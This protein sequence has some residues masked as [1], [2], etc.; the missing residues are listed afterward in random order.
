[1]SSNTEVPKELREKLARYIIDVKEKRNLGFNQLA[2]KA[3]INVKSLNLLLNG[4][5]KRIN[6]YQLQ[7]IA[8]ALK[9]DYKKLYEIVGY[10][11]SEEEIL[12]DFSLS[13]ITIKE[14]MVNVPVYDSL[15]DGVG[16]E[17]NSDPIDF[18]TLP[19]NMVENCV[20]IN[21]YD[22]SMRPTLQDGCRILVK[23]NVEINEDD[24]GVF[25][26]NGEMIVKRY[27]KFKNRIYLC[28]DNLNYPSREVRKEDSFCICGKV[29][30]VMNK[31]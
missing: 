19:E 12:E 23:K 5:N 29:I 28:S 7:K 4:T 16:G 25:I 26:H 10:L 3:H 31:V 1:M 13:E 9:I 22:D 15:S 14:T 18:V 6:P 17:S 27:K 30:W 11:E 2:F 8:T 21:I 24:M 20:I